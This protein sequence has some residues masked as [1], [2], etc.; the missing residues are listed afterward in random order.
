MEVYHQF[1]NCGT[2]YVPHAINIMG[3]DYNIEWEP[4]MYTASTPIIMAGADLWSCMTI[5]LSASSQTVPFYPWMVEGGGFGTYSNDWAGTRGNYIYPTQN[6][7]GF[8]LGA[9]AVTH[10][11]QHWGEII[12]AGNLQY[13]MSALGGNPPGLAEPLAPW[14][15]WN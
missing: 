7:L 13:Y 6:W 14:S 3:G 9:G 12:Y 5:D 4:L 11:D 15:V 1:G 10:W 8:Q 2:G